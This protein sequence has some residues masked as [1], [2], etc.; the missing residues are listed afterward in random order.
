MARRQNFDAANGGDRSFVEGFVTWGDPRLGDTKALDERLSV[1]RGMRARSGLVDTALTLRARANVETN[2]PAVREK[3]AK[4]ADMAETL[5][6]SGVRDRPTTVRSITRQYSNR[7]NDL[8]QN[9]A[10]TGQ[11]IPGTAWYFAHRRS[12]ESM[13]SPTSELSGRQVSAMGGKLSSGKTPD[14]E[15][16]SLGGISHLIST[17]RNASIGGRLVADISSEELANMA[18]AA[19]SWNAHRESGSKGRAPEM[20]EPDFGGNESLRSALV[21]AG[22]SHW[23]DVHSAIRIARGEV[24]PHELFDVGRTPKTAA[25]GEMGAQSNPNSDVEVDY[26]NISSHYRDV[27]A[28]TQSRDQGMLMFSQEQPGKRAYALSPD[29]PTAIDTWMIAAGSGQPQRASHVTTTSS[30]GKRTTQVR[31]AKRLTDKDF[32]LS[33]DSPTKGELGLSRGDTDITP[34]SV[35]SAQHNQAIQ[36]VSKNIGNVSFDQFGR[37]IK[38]PS[39]LIQ[40]SVWTDV[41][42]EAGADPEFNKQQNAA[43]KSATAEARTTAKREKQ[44]A[45]NY[46]QLD[47]GF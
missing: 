9:A 39:S 28:G 46:R 41:R 35:V 3:S 19:S 17:H 15:R 12:Q 30:G 33:S 20:P 45:K 34:Q 43:A 8:V 38:I 25:Y 18:T 29:S 22:R 40:E 13:L 11:E 14:D 26:R 27:V 6:A 23:Q 44:D 32:P 36:N 42:R 1:T 37:G 21:N 47:L 5:A 16:T 2:K 24:E 7:F 10:N 31:P 4:G